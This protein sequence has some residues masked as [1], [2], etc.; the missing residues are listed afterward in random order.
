MSRN[1][2]IFST[3]TKNE[4]FVQSLFFLYTKVYNSNFFFG[5]T[6][7]EAGVF[8]RG[9]WQQQLGCHGNDWWMICRDVISFRAIFR[10]SVGSCYTFPRPVTRSRHVTIEVYLKINPVILYGPSKCESLNASFSMRFCLPFRADKTLALYFSYFRGLS[11]GVRIFI[12]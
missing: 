11:E 10:L 7:V 1:K 4:L 9:K 3:K 5:T 12:R 2:N 6:Y 8:H